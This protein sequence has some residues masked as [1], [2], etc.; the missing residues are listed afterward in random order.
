VN[1]RSWPI[2]AGLTRTPWTC[3][4]RHAD[5]E[6]GAAPSIHLA[7]RRRFLAGV[8]RRSTAQALLRREEQRRYPILLTLVAQSAIDVLDESLLLFDQALS[9]REAAA[10]GR[11]AAD[12]MIKPARAHRA[13][14]CRGH[15]PALTRLRL[16]CYVAPPGLASLAARPVGRRCPSTRPARPPPYRLTQP[17]IGPPTGVDPR[18]ATACSAITRPRI[19]GSVVSWTVVFPTARNDTLGRARPGRAPPARSADSALPRRPG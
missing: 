14:R 6:Y 12:S 1:W 3:R 13:G 2:C 5:A 16:D 4:C 19:V 18:T 10:G 7:Q 8:G 9:G 17:P 15:R 11:R